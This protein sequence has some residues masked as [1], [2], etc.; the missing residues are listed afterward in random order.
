MMFIP[1]TVVMAVLLRI[2]FTDWSR[3]HIGNRDVA[4]V[5]LGA[6]LCF[7][8]EPPFN[9]TV[10]ATAY[11]AALAL[12]LPGFL[13]GRVSGG[14]V[15]LLC[16]LAPLWSGIELLT[17]FVHGVLVTGAAL[18]FSMYIQRPAATGV[19]VLDTGDRTL[20]R[21]FPLGTALMFGALLHFFT[22]W[23]AHA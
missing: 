2:G 16:A 3:R 7:L 1:G 5:A 21:G 11:A 18:L 14:D 9:F 22:Q 10:L 23:T 17:V 4:V 20:A 8:L 6:A 15:K 19:A 12:T 13:T